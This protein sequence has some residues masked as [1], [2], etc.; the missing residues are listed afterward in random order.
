M[1]KI[2][3]LITALV[4]FS[5]QTHAQYSCGDRFAVIIPHIYNTGLGV[6]GGAYPAEN[7]PWG[8]FVGVGIGATQSFAEA[9]NSEFGGMAFYGKVQYRLARWVGATFMAGIED[10]ETGLFGVGAR[11][12]IANS[13]NQMA[14]FTL[15]PMA[16]NKGFR[17]N[18]GIGFAL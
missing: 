11:V 10:F 18:A 9:S 3:S 2:Y 8:Y 15:E 1:R 16:T 14:V 6:E 5:V 7:Q 4:L 17:L 12:H 13:S